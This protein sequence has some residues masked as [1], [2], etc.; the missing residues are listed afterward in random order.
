MTVK[1]SING[2]IISSDEKWIYDYFEEEATC[3]RDVNEALPKNGEDVE[4]TINSWGGYV[5]QGAEIYTVL[6]SYE[7]KVTINVVSAYSAASVIAMAGDVVRI[8]PVGR[9]MIHNAASGTFGDYHAMDKNS[10]VLK[11]ANDS[12]ANAYRIKTGLSREDI[13]A[14]MDTETW[15]NA[16]QA[17]ELGFADEVMFDTVE[18]PRL[19]ANHGSGMLP[20]NVIDKAKATLEPPKNENKSIEDIVNAQVEKAMASFFDSQKDHNP[21]NIEIETG[22]NGTKL[23]SPKQTKSLIN[24]LRKGE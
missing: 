15:L 10:E 19:I 21:I 16:E 13:L 5:D 18:Q 12:I 11:N 7:G 20:K 24:R 6:K 4:I 1:I 23:V 17:V 22:V 8:S 9:M 2:P 14:K 3:A